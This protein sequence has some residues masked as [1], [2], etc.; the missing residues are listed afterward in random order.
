MG[1]N[2]MAKAGRQ[3]SGVVAKKQA[4]TMACN[5]CCRQAEAAK[6]RLDIPARK[7]AIFIAGGDSDRT[8]L[9]RKDGGA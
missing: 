8:I 4:V 1:G 5:L 2:G 3:E 7:L 9:L 6:Q